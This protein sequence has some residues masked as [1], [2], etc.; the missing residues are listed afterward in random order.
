MT[1]RDSEC[2]CD[3]GLRCT[4]SSLHMDVC[5]RRDIVGLLACNTTGHLPSPHHPLTGAGHASPVMTSREPDFRASGVLS[6]T[7]QGM[8]VQRAETHPA[9]SQHG[10]TLHMSLVTRRLFLCT[11]FFKL[12]ENGR[13]GGD[14][15]PMPQSEASGSRCRRDTNYPRVAPCV[16]QCLLPACAMVCFLFRRERGIHGPASTTQCTAR[17]DGH[18]PVA[19]GQRH[20]RQPNT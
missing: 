3:S 10:C 14:A 7:W 8:R 18:G 13:N 11:P 19:I 1:M 20:S 15:C 16:A 9:S 4:Q 6:G 17:L 12:Q 5:G 2:A